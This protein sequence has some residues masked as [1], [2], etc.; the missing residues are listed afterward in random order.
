MSASR[1]ISPHELLHWERAHRDAKAASLV[2]GRGLV[3]PERVGEA[4]GLRTPITNK[5]ARGNPT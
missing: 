3:L 1:E 2:S 5:N 4:L